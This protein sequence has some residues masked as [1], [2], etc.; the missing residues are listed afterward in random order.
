MTTD[1]LRIIDVD[2]SSGSVIERELTADEK[3]QRE[4]DEKEYALLLH[5]HQS[6]QERERAARSA[7]AAHAKSLGFTDEMIAVMY[8]GIASAE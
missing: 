7:A 5:Q 8:P 6:K 3:K 2:C 1:H 4:A